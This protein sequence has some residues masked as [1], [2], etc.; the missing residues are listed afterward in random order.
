MQLTDKQLFFH[1]ALTWSGEQQQSSEVSRVQLLGE[2]SHSE[3]FLES[4]IQ[5]CVADAGD[6][7]SQPGWDALTCTTR[8]AN[9]PLSGFKIITWSRKVQGGPKHAPTTTSHRG[10]G[11][12][13]KETIKQPTVIITLFQCPFSTFDAKLF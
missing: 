6:R 2:N 3:A 1:T 13:E 8:K 10:Q 5:L 12:S 11:H 7:C 4:S 9:Q